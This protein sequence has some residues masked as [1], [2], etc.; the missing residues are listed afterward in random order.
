MR[1][2]MTPWL[3]GELWI[4]PHLV[5]RTELHV[6]RRLGRVGPDLAGGCFFGSLTTRR[7]EGLFQGATYPLGNTFPFFLQTI[8]F[9]SKS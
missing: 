3:A 7:D 5:G 1:A 9:L 8:L 6:P 2:Y 4:L